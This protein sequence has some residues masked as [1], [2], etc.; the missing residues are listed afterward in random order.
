MKKKQL[1]KV[2]KGELKL[3]FL[4]I[5]P[6]V[7]EKLPH[8]ADKN[9]LMIKELHKIARYRKKQLTEVD[10]LADLFNS[11]I[12]K[13]DEEWKKKVSKKMDLVA[14]A[15]LAD[16]MPLKN[17]NRIIVSMGLDTIN[18]TKRKGLKEMILKKG[19]FNKTISSTDVVWQIIPVLNASG[20]MGEPDKALKLLLS[21]DM[22]DVNKLLDYVLDLNKKRKHLV[23]SIWNNTLRTAKE[24][25]NKTENRLIYVF[26]KKI[27]RGI[28][29]ILA[30]RLMNTFKLP[31]IVIALLENIGFGSIRSPQTLNIK[32]FLKMFHD[33]LLDYGGH[34]FAGGFS[35]SL[36]ELGKFENK[37]CLLSQAIEYGAQQAKTIEIDAEIP[38]AYLTPD[39]IKIVDLF[40]PYGEE[41]P[42]LLFLTRGLKI[43][44]SDL[45]GKKGPVHLKLLLDSG[46]YKWPAVF[47][48][49]YDKWGKEFHK[50]DKIDL[51]YK[52]SRKML[53]NQQTIQ[54]IVIDIKKHK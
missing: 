37:L 18:S 45:F 27:T 34:D 33:I 15:T 16:I 36:K 31:A 26:S 10:V 48:N 28:T 47:W 44:D 8:L 50:N 51:I 41:N 42:P 29:G 35:I 25:L 1:N 13:I 38:P 39:L 24:S 54:M 12:V 53:F 49:S 46:K 7:Q 20:R 30:S 52:L 5:K 43:L 11:L 9:L 32:D 6:I 21:Q 22:D 19:L 14:L 2:F 23:D 17:E 4:D 40:E 3:S